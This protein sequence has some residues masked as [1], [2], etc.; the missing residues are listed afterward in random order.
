MDLC[1]FIISCLLVTIHLSLGHPDP[2]SRMEEHNGQKFMFSDEMM[3]LGGDK[4]SNG[5]EMSDYDGT[6]NEE[7][8][9][10][11][12]T[13]AGNQWSRCVKK[14]LKKYVTE[15]ENMMQCNVIYEQECHQVPKQVCSISKTNPKLI[16]KSYVQT[17]CYNEDDANVDIKTGKFYIHLGLL[18]TTKL[19]RLH[20]GFQP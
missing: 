17:I 10:K 14:D 9:L 11:V 15:Y 19:D 6:L 4:D 3:M 1:C 8:D 18:F 12:I 5:Q 7:D 20:Q 2:G 13:K 16:E